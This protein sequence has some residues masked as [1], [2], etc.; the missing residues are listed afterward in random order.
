VTDR[1]HSDIEVISKWYR[2]FSLI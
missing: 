1:G 2:Y